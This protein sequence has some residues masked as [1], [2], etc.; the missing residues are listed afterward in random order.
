[1]KRIAVCYNGTIF[2]SKETMEELLNILQ[3][4]SVDADCL[5]ID[6]LKD[7]YDFVF[8]VGGDG[9]ILKTARFYSKSSTPIFGINLGRL[10]FL[11]QSSKEAYKRIKEP[12]YEK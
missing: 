6:N 8:V 5:D 12:V 2:N 4:C 10:G 3:G 1:M 7:N 9:T 11:S